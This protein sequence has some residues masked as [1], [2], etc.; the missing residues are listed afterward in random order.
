LIEGAPL[1]H[2]AAH[3]SF[4]YA[5]RRHLN[6]QQH[7]THSRIPKMLRHFNGYS[8]PVSVRHVT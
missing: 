7:T 4:T 6:N 2:T 1:E 5:R 8:V 3:D